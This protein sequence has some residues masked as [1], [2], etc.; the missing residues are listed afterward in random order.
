MADAEFH[1]SQG[2]GEQLLALLTSGEMVAQ[3]LHPW[4]SNYTFVVQLRDAEGREGLAM[5]KPCRGEAPL[6]DFPDG[7]LYRRERATYVVTQALGWD[8]VPTTVVRDG[9]YGVG[10]VQRYVEHEPREHYF[11]LREQFPAE[12]QRMCL[13]DL[14][15]NN[16]D[17]KSGHCLLGKEGRV[18]GVDHGLTFHEEGK[19]RT[20]IWDYAGEPIPPDMLH[21]LEALLGLLNSESAVAAEVQELLHPREVAALKERV[22]LLVRHPEFP[23]PP[24]ARRSWPWPMV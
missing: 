11:T 15:A 5:Y 18:W 10:A 8:F 4:A 2:D 16:A 20:V 7:T 23:E 19:L 14:L 17:R 22:E 24:T 9:P 21:D 3:Q 12:F 6:W 13:F 1:A